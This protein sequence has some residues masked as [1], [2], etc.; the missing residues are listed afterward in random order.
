MKKHKIIFVIIVIVEFVSSVWFAY[1][2]RHS[3]SPEWNYWIVGLAVLLGLSAMAGPTI[4][5]SCLI[6]III[7]L[8]I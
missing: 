1:H 5:I 8:L 7:G 2:T 4:I 3:S 6:G